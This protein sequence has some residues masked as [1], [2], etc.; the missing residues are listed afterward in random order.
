M[1]LKYEAIGCLILL[2]LLSAA[3]CGGPHRRAETIGPAGRSTVR[4]EDRRTPVPSPFQEIVRVHNRLRRQVQSPPL[5]WSPRLAQYAQ[6][7]ADELKERGCRP[8]HRKEWRYGEN[9]AWSDHPLDPEA[10]AAMWAREKEHFDHGQ[11]R[12]RPGKRC[13][14]YTQMIWRNTR[15]IGCGMAACGSA[16]IWVCNYNPPG[17]FMNRDPY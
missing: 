14:H 3:A 13:R 6:A 15:E 10:A 7:W 5:T 2:M 4:D 17:N 8:G 12:C 16:R 11:K 1:G 9:I